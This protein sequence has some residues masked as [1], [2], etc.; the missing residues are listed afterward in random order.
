M[1]HVQIFA[2][3]AVIVWLAVAYRVWIEVFDKEVKLTPILVSL[4][5]GAIFGLVLI[6]I[7]VGLGVLV[8][9]ALG[10]IP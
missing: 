9:A 6:L 4:L 2:I 10:I 1:N 8:G 7:V 5:F 3:I